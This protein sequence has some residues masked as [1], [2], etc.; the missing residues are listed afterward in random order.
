MRLKESVRK[1]IVVGLSFSR[2]S[3]SAAQIFC[4]EK[5]Q[6]VTQKGADRDEGTQQV[7]TGTRKPNDRTANRN[8]KIHSHNPE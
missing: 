8:N 5:P 7:V 1:I 6:S 4:E 2:S 3:A